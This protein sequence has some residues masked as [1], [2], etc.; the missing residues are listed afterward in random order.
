[1]RG[2][3]RALFLGPYA[4]GRDL[5]RVILHQILEFRARDA[6]ERLP[7][8]QRVTQPE[9]LVAGQYLVRQSIKLAVFRLPISHRTF[10]DDILTDRLVAFRLQLLGGGIDLLIG[11]FPLR[12]SVLR[13]ID[14]RFLLRRLGRQIRDGRLVRLRLLGR[15]VVLL[16]EGLLLLLELS[17]LGL[18]GS[19]LPFPRRADGEPAPAGSL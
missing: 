6:N 3:R 13:L 2:S 10:G 8:G 19:L 18:Q 17:F 12:Q 1:M 5:V 9:L 11:R 15:K 4:C 14:R 7:G 16:L